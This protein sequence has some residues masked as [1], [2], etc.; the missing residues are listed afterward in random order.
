M[1][2]IPTQV[3]STIRAIIIMISISSPT[4]A[5]RIHDAASEGD[6]SYVQFLL[7]QGVDVDIL[8]ES[9]ATPLHHAC[10]K[11][12]TQIVKLLLAYGANYNLIH[13]ATKLSALHYAAGYAN[14]VEIITMLI[15]AGADANSRDG[16]D[17]TPLH[18]AAS[19][20]HLEAYDAL[21]KNGAEQNIVNKY[22]KIPIQYLTI[23]L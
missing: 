23:F 4:A 14:N 16:N 20:Q 6:L 3:R 5:H 19:A 15:E 7:H 9:G 1:F 10:E 11:G 21:V 22:G 2:R 13:A 12:K 18:L 8:S 17:H